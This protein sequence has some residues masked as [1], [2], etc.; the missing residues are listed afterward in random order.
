MGAGGFL[1]TNYVEGYEELFTDREDLVFY[2]TKEECLEL[3]QHYLPLE[4]ERERIAHNG[5]V[6]T[7]ENHK[8]SDRMREVIQRCKKLSEGQR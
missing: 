1:L 2:H 7:H 4:E 5:F 6:K 3:I 8:F